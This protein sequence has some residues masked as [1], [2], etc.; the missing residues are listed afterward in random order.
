MRRV[1]RVDVV[2]YLLSVCRD[3]AVINLCTS[4]GRSCLHVAA[5]T[6]NVQLLRYLLDLNANCNLTV[7][8]KVHISTSH[9]ISI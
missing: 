5:L 8:F 7:S 9:Y 1:C 4:N 6:D 3:A 2:R